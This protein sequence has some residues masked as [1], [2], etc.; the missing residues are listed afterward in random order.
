MQVLPRQVSRAG[1]ENLVHRL[2]D[3]LKR[4]ALLD[5]LMLCAPPAIAGTCVVALLFH[6][7]WLDPLPALVTAT[8]VL[9]SA[10]VAVFL[11]WRPSRPSVRGAARLVDRKSGARD[12]FLTLATIDPASQPAPFIA[13]LRQQAEGFGHRVELARDFPYRF[14]RSAFWSFAVSLVAALLIYFILPAAPSAPQ[15]PSA[16]ERLAE[17]VQQMAA[18][19]ALRDLARG[20][21]DL[22]VKLDEPEV[23][24][25]EKQAAI[26]K[27]QQRIED[28]RAKVQES[29]SHDLLGEAASAVEGLEKEQQ[30]AGGQGQQQEKGSGGIQTNA[31]QRGEGENQ[32]NQ[33]GSGEG[34]GDSSAQLSQDRMD[35]G[36]TAQ[37]NPK[38]QGQNKNQAGEAK[39]QQ[40]Q[41]D[42]NQPSQDPSKD[43]AGKNQGDSKEGAGKQQAAEEPPPQGGPQADRFYKPG[44]GKEGLAGKKG[45]VTVQLPEEVVADSK[46]E[47][48]ISK[49]AKG[50]RT[51]V[52]V[53][54]SNVPLP[55]HV[56][57]A[58]TEKQQVPLEYRG[59][60]R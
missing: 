57:N 56:P 10:A 41:P 8:I 14:K 52:T 33:S 7:R 5:A 42:P 37:A 29:E 30:V 27:M 2:V 32:Q 39:N 24:P 50:N 4:H 22:S 28:Q 45:Y 34:K 11:R 21:K 15:R 40:K 18:R 20:L 53:P 58:P 47:S 59:I 17:L 38:E 6:A 51:R 48:A 43:K 60:L 12:H 16:Q 25:S 31:P 19:P 55:A 23:P 44:E 35:E 9:A 54:V 13:R 1:A 36:K 26:E 46:G 3:Q 49:D